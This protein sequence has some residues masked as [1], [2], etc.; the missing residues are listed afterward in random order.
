MESQQCFG[1][2]AVKTAFLVD[3]FT[4]YILIP[5]KS[6]R[7]VLTVCSVSRGDSS[8]N[9]TFLQVPSFSR[10]PKMG[11]TMVGPSRRHGAYLRPLPL[12]RHGQLQ[13][14]IK[15]RRQYGRNSKPKRL[16]TDN[17]LHWGYVARFMRLVPPV[18]DRKHWRR[19]RGLWHEFG[20]KKTISSG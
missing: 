7:L 13:D 9:N 5:T 19:W 8:C 10:A 18:A 4:V 2:P 20:Y 6:N 15:A 12:C 16:S 11:P 17:S 3:Q 14:T 1:A